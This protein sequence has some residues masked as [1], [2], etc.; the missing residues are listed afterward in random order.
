MAINFERYLEDL[1]SRIDAEAEQTI[2]D[3]WTLFAQGKLD[4]GRTTRGIPARRPAPPRIEWPDIRVNQSLE[5]VDAM[6]YSQLRACSGQLSTAGNTPLWMRSNYGVGTLPSVLGC[7]PFIMPE[8]TN[9]LPN[10]RSLE[11]GDEAIRR[12]LDN[13]PTD[14]SGGWGDEVF[15]VGRR[16]AE[17]RQQCPKLARYVCIDHPDGQGPI[18]LCELLWGSDMFLAF[19]DE[20][21][22]LHELLEAVTRF[23]IAFMDRWFSLVPG[24]DGYHAYFSRLHRGAIALRNDSLMNLS[25]E[26]YEEFVFPHDQALFDHFGGG[27]VHFCGT[28]THFIEAMSKTR[29]LYAIDMS[30]PHLNDMEHI[31]THTVDK[32]INLHVAD[33]EWLARIDPAAH[34]MT[35]LA[36]T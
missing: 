19:Y 7:K 25:G 32:G 29:G 21:D 4:G 6:V 15:E 16:F 35:R 20:A 5:S 26:L 2:L 31:L 33:G 14:M 8:E 10:V 36:I 13:W 24:L 9:C 28:G 12:L 1:E 17:I 22:L 34:N 27:L 18:D 11:G 30:Q 23:Y 3:G